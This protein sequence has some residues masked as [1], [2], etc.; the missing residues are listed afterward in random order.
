MFGKSPL[1]TPYR[2]PVASDGLEI[3]AIK[4]PDL[5]LFPEILE[6]I[7]RNQKELS[8]RARALQLVVKV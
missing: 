5:G 2:W 3:K 1:H 4:V 8:H 7:G 6:N